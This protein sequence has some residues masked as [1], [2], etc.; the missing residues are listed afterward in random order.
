MKIDKDVIN[1]T[2]INELRAHSWG[3]LFLVAAY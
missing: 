2:Q 1:S 3:L